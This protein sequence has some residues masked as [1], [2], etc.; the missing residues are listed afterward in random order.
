MIIGKCGNSHNSRKHKSEQQ[1]CWRVGEAHFYSAAPDPT[2]SR[3]LGRG[4]H[5]WHRRR[6]ILPVA[7]VDWYSDYLELS[8]TQ[9]GYRCHDLDRQLRQ[10]YEQKSFSLPPTVAM[11]K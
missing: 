7:Q 1:H 3:W 2:P 11:P 4:W 10:F 5:E 8:L 6:P 9:D